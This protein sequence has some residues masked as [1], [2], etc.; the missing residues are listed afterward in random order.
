MINMSNKLQIVGFTGQAGVGKDTAALLLT[1]S[2]QA[3]GKRVERMGF[4]DPI[5]WMLGALGVT[6]GE[7]ASRERKEQ[8]L[9][10]FNGNS[11]RRMM[12]TL[13][14]EWGRT[15]MG[16]DFWV[17]RLE[18]RLERLAEVGKRPDYLLIT[19]VRF[20]NEGAWVERHGGTMVAITRRQAMAVASH[21]SERHLVRHTH[22]IQ[23]DHDLQ[24][25]RAQVEQVACVLLAHHA[26]EA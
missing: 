21:E 6:E 18:A 9:A 12:Q 26:L 4:A 16:G 2:L 7:L 14:T 1:E 24:A 8:P 11:P 3:R 5:R 13:G 15:E 25:L 17:K 10:A 20:P 22:L 19:D 23:N